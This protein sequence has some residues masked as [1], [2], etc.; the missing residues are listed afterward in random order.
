[1][2][3][4]C[5]KE[6]LNEH[7]RVVAHKIT[8]KEKNSVNVWRGFRLACGFPHLRVIEAIPKGTMRARM[9]HIWLEI[10][11]HEDLHTITMQFIP[12]GNQIYLVKFTYNVVFE[13]GKEIAS[14]YYQLKPLA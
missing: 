1:M 9:N 4:V 10:S 7:R 6:D 2:K 12:I 14:F 13:E 3:V 8:K 5:L 11:H